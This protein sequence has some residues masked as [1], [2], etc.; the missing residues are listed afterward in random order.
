MTFA[1]PTN[2]FLQIDLAEELS[3]LTGRRVDL[4]TEIHSAS[5][6]YIVPTMVAL[7]L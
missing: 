7:P 1:K 2:L 3:A 4:M 5:T 6:P